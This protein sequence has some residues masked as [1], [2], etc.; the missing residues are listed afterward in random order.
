MII[1]QGYKGKTVAV[2]GLARAGLA[3]AAALIAGGARVFAWDDNVAARDA[4]ADMG[5]EIMDIKNAPW[6]DIAALF[7]SPGI[8]HLYPKP[9]P[10]IAEAVRQGVAIDNDIG[11]FFRSLTLGAK[12]I[13]VTGSNGKST[14]TALLA[15]VLTRLNIPVQM[16]GNIGQAVMGLNPPDDGIVVLELSSYQTELA[17]T[18]RPD[19]A[20]FANFSPDHLDRHGGLGGYF[21]AKRR[22][23]EIGNPAFSVVGLDEAEGRFIAGSVRGDVIGVVSENAGAGWSICVAEG[24]LSEWQNGA[25][26]GQMDVA[27]LDN[28]R[29]HHN[30]QNAAMVFATCRAL[31]FAA[32]AICTAM[33]EFD[34]LEH[35]CQVIGEKDG[36]VFVN[37]S[38]ATNIASVGRALSVFERIHWIVGGQKRDDG[39]TALAP[40]FGRVKRA[41]LIG[42]SAEDFAPDLAGVAVEHCGTLAR[43]VEAVMDNVQR[44]DV[45]LLAPACASFD[46]FA[47]FEERGD[48]FVSLIKPYLK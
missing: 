8:A 23:F 20:L 31:G 2:L 12:V 21:A 30:H 10:I 26:I 36:V 25:Q 3:T 47:S 32:P 7:V 28:L 29:G 44:G 27:G 6:G 22:L 11:L 39:L 5:A 17:Q 4:G 34:G 42:E 35:R 14:I 13:C 43:A 40:L 16:G 24:G 15:H 37:N 38:K 9:H 41:Y 45:V 18:L 19:I 46:Q 33:Q 1:A 48:V